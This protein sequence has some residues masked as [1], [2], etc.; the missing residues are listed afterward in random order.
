MFAMVNWCLAVVQGTIW[1]WVP[2]GF[3]SPAIGPMANAGVWPK[4]LRWS[5]GEPLTESVRENPPCLGAGNEPH[6][7]LGVEPWTLCETPEP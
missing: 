4:F 1:S 3:P 7:A 5:H 6:S 2:L